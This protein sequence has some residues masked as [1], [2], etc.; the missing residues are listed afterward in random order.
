MFLLG[1]VVLATSCNKEEINFTNINGTDSLS[2]APA[3]VGDWAYQSGQEDYTT[4]Y[5]I[6]FD[7]VFSPEYPMVRDLH[8][9]N[10][11]TAIVEERSIVEIWPPLYVETKY[12]WSISANRTSLQLMGS[13]GELYTWEILMLTNQ[14][15]RVKVSRPDASG[16]GGLITSINTYEKSTIK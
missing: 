12:T 16:N 1:V 14:Q 11:G 7:T 3:L 10:D 15:L 5:P 13:L 2:S 9:R 6:P 4:N 8:F